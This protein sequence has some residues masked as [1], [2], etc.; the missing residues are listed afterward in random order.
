MAGKGRG[1]PRRAALRGAAA[2][3][4]REVLAERPGAGEI[5]VVINLEAL[6]GP[7]LATDEAKQ[8]P[9]LTGSASPAAPQRGAAAAL[10]APP[11]GL[12]FALSSRAAPFVPRG[13]SQGQI[14]R[15]S[16]RALCIEAALR[17]AAPTATSA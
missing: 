16:S 6:V 2:K 12:R 7:I 4:P 5:P 14:P 13:T 8:G 9:V 3:K 17:A 10:W 15:E 1:S 11:P